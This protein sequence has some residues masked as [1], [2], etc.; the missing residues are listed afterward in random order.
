MTDDAQLLVLYSRER[1]EAAFNEFVQRHLSLVYR[2]A[3]RQ[4]NGRISRC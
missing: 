1:S 3:L 2:A 4:C